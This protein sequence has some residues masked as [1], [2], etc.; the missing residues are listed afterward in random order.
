MKNPDAT[1]DA[2]LRGDARA[3]ARLMREIDEQTRLAEEALRELVPHLGKA[4]VVGITGPPGTGKSTLVDR[5][6]FAFRKKGMTVGVLAVD[7]TS[8]ISGG[9]ILGDR[10]RMQRHATDPGVFIRS[11]ATRGHVGGL[12]PSVYG[13]VAVLDALG[14]EIILVETVGVGQDAVEIA[15]LADTN[16]LVTIPGT[17]DG[18]QVLKAGILETATIFVVNKSDQEGADLAVA[19]LKALQTM[20]VSLPEG[21]QPP[22]LKT[23]AARDQ[24]TDALTE[25]ICRHREYLKNHPRTQNRLDAPKAAFFNVLKQTLLQRALFQLERENRLKAL[26]TALEQRQID[27]FSAAKQVAD[28]VLDPDIEDA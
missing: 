23:V 19:D 15:F 7:P 22:V 24:G 18:I 8:P 14:K 26:F 9:A 4:H 27:P 1:I 12:S 3:A 5:L 10:V 20:G 25:A 11:V 21:W 13:M 16:V 2:I 28:A 6:I 17:G